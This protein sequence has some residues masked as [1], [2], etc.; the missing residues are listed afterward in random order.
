MSTW[1]VNW[2][3]YQ[4][5]TNLS[6]FPCQLKP[7]DA[8]LSNGLIQQH[9]PERTDLSGCTQSESGQG[10]ILFDSTLVSDFSL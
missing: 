8:T 3:T 10:S 6:G 2:L 5:R 9:F 4:V 1:P 7:V